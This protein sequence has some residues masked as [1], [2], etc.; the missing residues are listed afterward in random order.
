MY[1]WVPPAKGVPDYALVARVCIQSNESFDKVWKK[2]IN[3]DK[4]RASNE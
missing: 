2:D 3:F 4:W 1:R